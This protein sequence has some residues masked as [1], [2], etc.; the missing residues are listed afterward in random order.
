MGYKRKNIP[1]ASKDYLEAIFEKEE[2]YLTEKELK[3]KK[4]PKKRK[5]RRDK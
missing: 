5:P 4:N 1:I 3:E 2:E